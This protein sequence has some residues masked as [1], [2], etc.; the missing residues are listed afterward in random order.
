[1][2]EITRR[3]FMKGVVGA[4][5]GLGYFASRI[6][7]FSGRHEVGWSEEVEDEARMRN[8]SE[9]SLREKLKRYLAKGNYDIYCMDEEGVGLRIN[10]ENLNLVDKMFGE[11]VKNV[12]DA[13]DCYEIGPWGGGVSYSIKKRILYG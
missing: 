5:L 9:K 8:K 10:K 4:G 6:D 2:V 13:F 3:N 7:G 12:V 11:F 1:M